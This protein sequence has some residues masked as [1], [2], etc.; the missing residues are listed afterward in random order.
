MRI[1]IGVTNLCNCD[2]YYNIEMKHDLKT[3]QWSD[4]P[5]LRRIKLPRH[6]K[7]VLR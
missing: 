4:V 5:N 6:V 7:Q 2:T 1:V 3:I